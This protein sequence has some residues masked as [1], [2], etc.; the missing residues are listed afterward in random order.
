MTTKKCRSERAFDA[1]IK[2]AAT[3][4]TLFTIISCA[5]GAAMGYGLAYIGEP[6]AVWLWRDL[7]GL[8]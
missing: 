6:R 1:I 8:L 4:P 2:F 7:L 5:I 3:Q